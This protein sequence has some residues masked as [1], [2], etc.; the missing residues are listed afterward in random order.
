MTARAL[1]ANKLKQRLKKTDKPAF[2]RICDGLHEG[3]ITLQFGPA[4]RAEALRHYHEHVRAV[5][6][7]FAHVLKS[8]LDVDEVRPRVQRTHFRTTTILTTPSLPHYVTPAQQ[9]KTKN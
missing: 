8:R 2:L 4:V 9:R 3:L 1:V 5:I 7:R 6:Q